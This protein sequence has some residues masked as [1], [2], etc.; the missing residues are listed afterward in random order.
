MLILESLPSWSYTRGLKSSPEIPDKVN[1]L[2]RTS[3]PERSSV[4]LF[5]DFFASVYSDSGISYSGSSGV[6]GFHV[7]SAE[8]SFS[9]IVKKMK[10]LKPT[11][12]LGPDG[13]PS[14][15]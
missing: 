10:C 13:I 3:P 4:D 2:I 6:D 8:L 11:L 9:D 5:A 1:Y 12:D 14:F 7:S 15:L